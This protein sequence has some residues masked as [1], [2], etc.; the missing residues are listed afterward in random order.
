LNGIRTGTW[1]APLAL[2]AALAAGAHAMTL[3]PAGPAGVEE[4]I[5]SLAWSPD[6]ATIAAHRWRI[7][8]P[9][10]VVT[11]KV[12]A[13]DVASGDPVPVRGLAALPPANLVLTPS[14]SPDSHRLAVAA[15]FRLWI[16]N[17]ADSAA[18]Q[19]GFEDARRP[20][21]SPDGSQF[22]FAGTNGLWRL[23]AGGGVPVRLTTGLDA[24][25]TWSH[26]GTRIAFSRTGHLYTVP[27][28]G[29]TPV[30]L[31]FGPDSDSEPSWS[32]DGA[33]IAFSSN[34][35]GRNDLWVV[36]TA[37]GQLSQMTND[38]AMD[39]SPEWSPDGTAIAFVSDR[40]GA[41]RVWI[42][43]DL[44]LVP[45]APASWSSVKARYR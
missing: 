35:G 3:R 1:L 28:S 37:T 10:F 25:P 42:A 13:F 18:V 14:W 6:G 20:S 29:G 5:E 16:V 40:D 43:T 27:G 34:R 26:D 4:G 2:S 22:V 39:S 15:D 32:P 19:I 12:F 7:A 23:P 11:A 36:R 21:W 31:T 24:S 17:V 45:V 41:Q 8:P 38:A 44:S 9:D 30:P 33:L